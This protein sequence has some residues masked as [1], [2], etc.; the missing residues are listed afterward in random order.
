MGFF[1]KFADLIG[2][3]V[4][5]MLE[6][7]QDPVKLAK[8]EVAKYM[9]ALA[10]C[11][12]DYTT[13][14]AQE[15]QQLRLLNKAKDKYAEYEGMARKA[16]ASGDEEGARTLL[17]KVQPELAQAQARYD[18]AQKNSEKM[19]ATYSKLAADV[20][21]LKAAAQN[22]EASVALAKSTQAMADMQ[23]KYS[24]TSAAGSKLAA[25]Q[26]RVQQQLDKAEAAAA[27]AE[28]E[29]EPVDGSLEAK[30]GGGTHTAAVDSDIERLKKEMGL[31]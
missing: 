11:R 14:K 1:D 21:T 13:I 18:A 31:A 23:A 5:A 2:S 6:K 22:I 20:E 3:N 7:A 29:D 9:D 25:A 19:R 12:D 28:E 24:T 30:Y 8:Y 17:A 27:V 10:E 26:E 4:N 16:L 15:A